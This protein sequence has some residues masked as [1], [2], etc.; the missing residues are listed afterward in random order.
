MP[1]TV[2]PDCQQMDLGLYMGMSLYRNWHEKEIKHLWYCTGHHPVRRRCHGH[3][4]SAF[5]MDHVLV[6]VRTVLR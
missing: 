1:Q 4:Q 3:S 2:A 6:I 5:G